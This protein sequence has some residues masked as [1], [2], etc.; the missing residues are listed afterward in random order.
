ME[1]R[2][3]D[4]NAM[5]KAV[6]F[7]LIHSIISD[8]DWYIKYNKFIDLDMIESKPVQ[9]FM[10]LIQT[11]FERYG[12]VPSLD[13]LVSEI[14]EMKKAPEWEKHVE[15]ID[16][17]RVGLLDWNA[18]REDAQFFHDRFSALLLNNYLTRMFL[19]EDGLVDKISAI[20]EDPTSKVH[21]EG[22]MPIL[23]K[24]IEYH[25]DLKL[26]GRDRIEAY[27]VS[28]FQTNATSEFIVGLEHIDK[29]IVPTSGQVL[30]YM[31]ATGVGKSHALIHSATQNLK[32]GAKVL[33]ITL[34]M[35]NREVWLRYLCSHAGVPYDELKLKSEAEVS[36]IWKPFLDRGSSL[37]IERCRARQ[38]TIKE[39]GR[40]LEMAASSSKKPDIVVIDYLELMEVGK[41]MKYTE[42]ERQGIVSDLLKGLA[43]EHDILILTATQSNRPSKEKKK[44]TPFSR[45][46]SSYAKLHSLDFCIELLSNGKGVGEMKN[47]E[48]FDINLFKSRTGATG[49]FTALGSLDRSKFKTI[50]E[51]HVARAI[52]EK[53]QCR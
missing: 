18:N 37:T 25:S 34:E 28:Q 29:K 12:K 35:E 3:Y 8:P 16:A 52:E 40:I 7:G 51:K 4:K 49:E 43:Q 44:D 48:Y 6:E 10:P 45:V 20:T 17:W 38:F 26:A 1:T 23:T 19:N 15:I 24:V 11:Q 22:I 14:E 47:I 27:Q 33:H 39:L 21:Y 53:N 41:G 13:M 42:Y 30:C 9:F 2:E 46:G 50:G 32:N 31:A 36:A 5:L